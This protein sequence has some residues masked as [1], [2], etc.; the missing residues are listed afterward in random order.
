MD[1]GVLITETHTVGICANAGS[2][3]SNVAQTMWRCCQ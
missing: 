3:Q 1:K 2:H